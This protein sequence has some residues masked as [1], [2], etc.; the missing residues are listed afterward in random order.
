MYNNSVILL[1]FDDKEIYQ[2][3]YECLYFF[4]NNHLDYDNFRKQLLTMH[5][6]ITQE[7]QQ[8]GNYNFYKII[9]HKNKFNFV[10]WTLPWIEFINEEFIASIAPTIKISENKEE[11]LFTKSFYLF[12]ENQEIKNNIFSF[13]KKKSVENPQIYADVMD[14]YYFYEI[15]KF[16]RVISFSIIIDLNDTL[17]FK[18]EIHQF[19][20]IFGDNSEKS[21]MKQ[22]NFYYFYRTL[23]GIQ[24]DI[25]HS[26]SQIDNKNLIRNIISR[27]LK[28]HAMFCI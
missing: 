18:I 8:D 26:I 3:H 1:E 25:S 20:A 21:L 11:F 24:E 13:L 9:E 4:L 23:E 5:T 19:L 15:E 12:V 27:N 6:K 17:I 10:P 14:S 16:E 22:K 28:K 2:K 7:I